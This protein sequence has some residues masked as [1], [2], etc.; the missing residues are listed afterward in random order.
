MSRQW[1]G[2]QTS[3][4]RSRGV[5][6][7]L[8]GVKWKTELLECCWCQ[9]VAKRH[10][11]C[12]YLGEF[13]AHGSGDQVFADGGL[14]FPSDQRRTLDTRLLLQHTCVPHLC[15][16]TVCLPHVSLYLW[17]LTRF[18][19]FLLVLNIFSQTKMWCLWHNVEIL[20]TGHEIMKSWN[21]NINWIPY[22]KPHRRPNG[23]GL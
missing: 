13:T 15:P 10:W 16:C 2:A 23:R 11:C 18:L 7:G 8:R 21:N 1:G 12:S 6:R 14:L 4:I 19:F 3:V 20:K 9:R 17:K 5:K 22:Y